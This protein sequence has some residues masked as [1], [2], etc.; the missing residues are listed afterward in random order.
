M[1]NKTLKFMF[2]GS[3]FIGIL[4]LLF[5]VILTTGLFHNITAYDFGLTIFIGFGW[6][7][8][9][10]VIYVYS[11]FNIGRKKKGRK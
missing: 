10:G 9:A 5:S 8:F 4:F 1:K 6:L 7:I 11:F 3:M 2:F